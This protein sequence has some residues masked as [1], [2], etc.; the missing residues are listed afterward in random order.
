[1]FKNILTRFANQEKVTVA[2]YVKDHSDLVLNQMKMYNQVLI[3]ACAGVGYMFH[4]EK[5]NN[6]HRFAQV[7]KQFEQVDKRFDK[8]E[9]EI[10]EI[11][12]MN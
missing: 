3:V 10:K 4:L 11:G 7:D 1:M 9:Y 6:D 12:E 2:R 8:L 5:E